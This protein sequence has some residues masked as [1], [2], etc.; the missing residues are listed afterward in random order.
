MV[1]TF[2]PFRRVSLKQLG[3]VTQF[4]VFQWL[5]K[6]LHIIANFSK[7]VFQSQIILKCAGLNK[8][9]MLIF[10]ALLKIS[11]AIMCLERLL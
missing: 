7:I 5:C 11:N 4:S 9:S 1:Y 8:V 3:S 10:A 2:L 6:E